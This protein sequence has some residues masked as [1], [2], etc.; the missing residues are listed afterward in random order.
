MQ[1]KLSLV[2]H[3]IKDPSGKE[4]VWPTASPFNACSQL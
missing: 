4:L 1:I 3:K 2:L